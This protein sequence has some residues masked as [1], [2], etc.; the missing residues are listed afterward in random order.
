MSFFVSLWRKAFF[1]EMN[2]V[3]ARGSSRCL[4]A[5]DLPALP[6]H[7]DPTRNPIAE[8]RIRWSSGIDILRSLLLVAKRGWLRS[9]AFYFGFAFFNLCGPVL[10]N[11]FVR[12]IEG[13][14]GA[15]PALVEA[16]L[17]ALC[18]GGTG[19]CGGLCIQ[20]YFHAN[21]G[22]GQLVVNLVN[23]RL[24]R[25]A[26][27]L[28]KSARERIPVGDIVN[29]LSVD[30]D[31]VSEAT[32]AVS[33]FLYCLAMIGGALGLLFHY[34]G[35]T[36]WVAVALLGA[37]VPITRKVSREFTKNDESLMKHRDA[38]VSLMAQILGAIRLVKYFVWESSVGAEVARVRG[39]EL[40]ARRRIAR[41][42]LLVTLL[43]VSVGTFVLFSVLAVYVWRGGVLSSA[44]VFTC[45][46][47]FSLLEDPFAFLS[48][49]LSQLINA[50]VGAERIARFLAEPVT[51]NS[52]GSLGPTSEPLGFAMDGV[53]V[54]L[55]EAR[56]PA[57]HEIHVRLEPGQSLAVVGPV[58]SGKTTFLH[59]LLGETALS[60]G[61]VR[62]FSANGERVGAARIGYVPQ[63]AYILNG[64]LREN[65]A[66]G[67]HA[68]PDAELERVLGLAGLT[69]DVRAMPGG[70][71]TEIGEKGINLSGGQRQRLSLARAALHAP[72]LVVLDDPLSAVDPA[73]E[74]L[75]V[76][77]LLMGEWKAVTRI[78]VTHRLEHLARF[79][80]IAFLEGGRVRGLG[81]FD[82]L[83]ASCPAFRAYLEEFA[84]SHS[85]TDH[86]HEQAH[87]PA[88]TGEA[89]RITE[90]E[91]REVGAV[92]GSVYWD[93]L[94]SLGGENRRTRPWILL[95]LFLA[96]ASGTAFPLAQKTWLAFATG[97]FSPFHVVCVYGALGLLVLAGALGA[98]LFWL[99]RGLAA[100]RNIH[101]KML[102]SILGA[103]LRF[104]RLHPRGAHP[105]AV[106]RATW[107]RSISSS[108]GRSRTR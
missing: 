3:I 75:L 94:L 59:T 96:A 95:A 7:F 54:H 89:T 49:T 18:V 2:P 62:L 36:A 22:R 17:L 38:R 40:V 92:R 8:E 87:G 11:A 76:R 84:A 108:S 25:H 78:A 57:L 55:G 46:S 80:R 13:G 97:K 10:V 99:R 106:S 105:A 5:E 9:M 65:L 74:E 23:T 39:E 44:L 51:T 61:E 90:D 19:L 52:L 12:R 63:E 83:S 107:R 6:P 21:L 4:E 85:A 100:G 86:A 98:D 14:L 81:T 71:D 93:Y 50:K 32:G 91:D 42:E 102:R 37:L 103:N 45:V 33:D 73:T 29:H 66:F 58:G 43:Y 28:E 70:L 20:H 104:F 1:S 77:Q 64:T 53:S 56:F 30:T 26:L 34:I 79:D 41:A 31:A 27:A 47:L 67:D 35:S 68:L 69:A 82:E 60:A 15:T 88:A 16:L 72:Q 48:R 24:F 101:D